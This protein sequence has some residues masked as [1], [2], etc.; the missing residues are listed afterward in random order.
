MCRYD[1][2]WHSKIKLNEKKNCSEALKQMS[3]RYAKYFDRKGHFRETKYIFVLFLLL[4][5]VW[6]CGQAL[7][8][9]CMVK[10]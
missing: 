8:H 9:F 4:T 5:F 10:K 6:H 7:W 3:G 2:I 1:K